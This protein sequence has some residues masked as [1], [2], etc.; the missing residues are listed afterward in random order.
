VLQIWGDRGNGLVLGHKRW[1][2]LVQQRNSA[3][4]VFN[5]A[6][7]YFIPA[8]SRNPYTLV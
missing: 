7:D 4:L 3:M 8:I 5:G 1:N 6:D 2:L